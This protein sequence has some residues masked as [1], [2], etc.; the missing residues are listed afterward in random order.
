MATIAF[1]SNADL[2]AN[3]KVHSE[4]GGTATL[5]INEE[6]PKGTDQEIPA[7]TQTLVNA[8]QSTV[9]KDGSPTNPYATI[10]HVQWAGEEG[11]KI[12]IKRGG[13]II[14][15]L[16]GTPQGILTFEGSPMVAETTNKYD[17][18]VFE[19]SGKYDAWI[20]IRKYDYEMK[21]GENAYYGQYEDDERV[22]ASTTTDGSWDYRKE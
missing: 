19:C 13:D 16:T 5:K 1:L 9:H 2:V 10:R 21:A 6:L 20:V 12:V 22:G 8:N 18:F 17:D 7:E 14:M 15:T 3:I 4:N 11:A